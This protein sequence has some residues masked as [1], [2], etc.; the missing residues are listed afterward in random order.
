MF[1]RLFNKLGERAAR[2]RFVYIRFPQEDW[3]KLAAFC[4]EQGRDDLL[5][6]ARLMLFPVA[7]IPLHKMKF[8][9]FPGPPHDD[10][11]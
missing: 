11:V 2:L 9:R 3:K 8:L 6:H 7:E 5:V 4:H 1:D 10:L